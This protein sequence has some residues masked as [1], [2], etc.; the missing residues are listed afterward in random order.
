MPKKTSDLLKLV[1]CGALFLSSCTTPP[2]EPLSEPKPIQKDAPKQKLE[3]IQL[4]PH[5]A[6]KIGRKIWMN[7]GLAKTEN[8][9]VWNK[10]EEFASLGIG[11]FIWY[12]KSKEGPYTETFPQ[13]IAFLQQEGVEIPDWLQKTPD[14]PWKSHEAFKYH[15][16]RQD[17]K[18][19]RTLLANTIPEQVRFLIKRLDEALPKMLDTLPSE[20]EREHVSKQ[21]YRVANAPNGL[22]ALVDYVNFKGEGISATERYQGQGWG[23]LQVLQKMPGNSANVMEEFA[24]AAEFV[25]TR[26]IQNSPPVRNESRWLK[27]WKNRIKTYTYTG[28][29]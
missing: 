10:G 16:Q 20:A 24:Q 18:E 2:P 25:L 9:T 11:H 19:L 22:Y 7:E 12:P 1:C 27:G 26:R 5:D 3:S 28:E 6:E 21:F 15:E 17:M 23:L 29:G 13:L 4:E 14:A 8:L